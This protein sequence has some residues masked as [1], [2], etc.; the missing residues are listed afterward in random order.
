MKSR[1]WEDQV[2]ERPRSDQQ[3]Q[4]SQG[5]CELDILHEQQGDWCGLEEQAGQERQYLFQSRWSEALTGRAG[6]GF[7]LDPQKG[8]F[9]T[10][11]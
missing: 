9:A 1:L 6:C 10:L 5:L 8:L 4:R 7:P 11:M 2:G 3:V